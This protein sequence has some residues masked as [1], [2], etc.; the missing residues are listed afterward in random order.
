VPI[1]LNT[2]TTGK[3]E[4]LIPQLKDN[5]IDLLITSPP[6]NVDLGSN[7]HNKTPYD[8]YNDNK[9]HKEYIKWLC[10]IFREV[11]PKMVSGGRVCINIGD[12]KNG[13]VPTHSDIIQFM[14]HELKYLLKTTSVG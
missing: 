7:K 3:C 4:E 8:M 6:Y 10:N 13:Q 1:E 9:D 2:I 14:S 5:S 12:G 11:K